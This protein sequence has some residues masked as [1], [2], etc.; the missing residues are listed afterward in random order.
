MAILTN[1]K[2]TLE[3]PRV[4]HSGYEAP[5]ML[6]R[7]LAGTVWDHPGHVDGT[8]VV[9]GLVKKIDWEQ[10]W[11]YTSRTTYILRGPPDPDWAEW[12]KKN[13]PDLYKNIEEKGN[14]N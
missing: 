2:L 13:Y 3:H 6:K 9:T 4:Y 5:E 12:V 11:A 1:W 8:P 14:G 10:R 7:Y